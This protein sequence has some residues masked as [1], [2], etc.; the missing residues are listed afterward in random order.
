MSQDVKSLVIRLQKGD[1]HALKELY[2]IYARLV[3]HVCRQHRLGD[4]DAE[5][6]LQETFIS[7]LEKS[8]SIIEASKVKAWLCMT[9]RNK[10]I[11]THRKH[12][13]RKQIEKAKNDETLVSDNR[14]QNIECQTVVEEILAIEAETGD[15]LLRLRYVEGKS[16]KEI[17]IIKGIAVSTVTTNLTRNRREFADRIKQKISQLREAKSW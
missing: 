6:V 9:A 7:L 5:D 3:L 4:Q 17:A 15:S 14:T 2:R 11:D 12:I 13:K 1:D 10:A 16:V 8:G